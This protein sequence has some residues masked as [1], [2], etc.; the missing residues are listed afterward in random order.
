VNN[1]TAVVESNKPVGIDVSPEQFRNVLTNVVTDLTRLNSPDGI[2]P[3][4]PVHPKNTDSR[5]FTE[6]RESNNPV[7]IEPV[8]C[9]S[10]A[11]SPLIIV[12]DLV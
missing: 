12:T 2:A 10:F 7:G 4:S 11:N 1:V 9:V 3:L 5:V 6:G 8:K